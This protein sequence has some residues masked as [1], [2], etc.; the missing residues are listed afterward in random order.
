M[1][2]SLPLSV[3]P[4]PLLFPFL[5]GPTDH[6]QMEVSAKEEVCSTAE[7]I[8][9]TR[10]LFINSDSSTEKNQHCHSYGVEI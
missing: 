2:W 1:W 9:A 4:L 10:K 8:Q 5:Q 3:L 6:I 7:I